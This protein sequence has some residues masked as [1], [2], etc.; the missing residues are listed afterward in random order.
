MKAI[1]ARALVVVFPCVAM[2]QIAVLQIKVLEGEGVVHPPGARVPRPL[3]VEVSDENGRPVAGAAVTFQLPPEGASGLFSNGLRTDLVVTD[4]TGR[5]AIHSVQLNRTGGQFRIRITAVKEQARA[6]AVSLQYIGE[7]KP[8]AATSAKEGP[9]PA[10]G[11]PSAKSGEI[12]PTTTK[13]GSGSH[14]KWVVL[15]AIAA[16]GGAAFAGVSRAAAHGSS[17]SSSVVNIGT[18]NITVGHP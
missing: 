2:A 11:P 18:P 3:T 14:K 1:L 4:A 17:P 8:A 6:G 9:G 10:H 5:A 13:M 15:A 12:T 16:A 7:N